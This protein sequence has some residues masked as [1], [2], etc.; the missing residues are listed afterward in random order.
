MKQS[1]ERSGFRRQIDIPSPSRPLLETVTLRQLTAR[2]YDCPP[3]KADICPS[4][5]L[6]ESVTMAFSCRVW[7]PFG[8][9]GSQTGRN[10]P[11]P[12]EIIALSK[13][14]PLIPNR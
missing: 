8:R 10:T 14:V 9:R 1:V 7:L 4:S 6:T 2:Y 13:Q 12:S 3:I 5:P 11:F